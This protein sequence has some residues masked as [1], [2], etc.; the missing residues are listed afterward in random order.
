MVERDDRSAKGIFGAVTRTTVHGP[1][2]TTS[3][4]VTGS[5]SGSRSSRNARSTAFLGIGV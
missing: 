3:V 4:A 5:S 1:S 2:A